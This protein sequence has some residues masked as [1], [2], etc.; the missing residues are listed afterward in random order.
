MLAVRSR[1]RHGLMVALQP[2]R[3][4]E[5][6]AQ[7]APSSSRAWPCGQIL[8]RVA[9]SNLPQGTRRL[10]RTTRSAHHPSLSRKWSGD[11]LE[12]TTLLR[13]GLGRRGAPS[14]KRVP[15][16]R[17]PDS[18]V[19]V[20]GG[21]RGSATATEGPSSRSERSSAEECSKK[22]RRSSGPRRF[23]TGIAALLRVT[24]FAPI[25]RG[26][27]SS[28]ARSEPPS[29]LSFRI[30][31]RVR[32]HRRSRGQGLG[33]DDR[34]ADAFLERS[35]SDDPRRGAGTEAIGDPSGRNLR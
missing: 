2:G 30:R 28:Y 12:A 17:E 24:T 10:N 19:A 31:S 13:D 26:R 14:A 16:R 15:R 7:Q 22:W 9:S 34:S 18:E 27:P 23:S 6:A 11:G 25:L 5:P 4:Q 1:K 32:S 8:E 33:N 20:E 3:S 29:F 21:A 35:C